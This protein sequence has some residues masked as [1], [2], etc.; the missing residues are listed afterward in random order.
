MHSHLRLIVAPTYTT[1]IAAFGARQVPVVLKAIEILG[2]SQSRGW[3]TGTL[4]ELRKFMDLTP[5][6]SFEDINPDP[7]IQETLKA[8][9]KEPDLVEMYPGV[10]FE[11]AKEPYFPGSGLCAGFTITR[12]I[13]SDAVTLVRGDR[14]YTLVCFPFYRTTENPSP[15]QCQVPG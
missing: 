5:H 10:V 15:L 14:F 13:L 6:K 4:N 11:A 9:Y 7:E 1:P 3:H 2:I 12:A 8:L